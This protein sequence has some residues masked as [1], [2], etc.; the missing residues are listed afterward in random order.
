MTD[1]ITPLVDALHDLLDAERRALLAGDLDAIARMLA[2]KEDILARLGTVPGGAPPLGPLMDKLQRNQ[3]LLHGALDGIRTVAARI[4]DARQ[5]R[6]SLE[7]YDKRGQRRSIPAPAAS[8]ER[9]A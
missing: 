7:T 6:A 3:V 2:R 4:A 1:D 5:V 9:R 8:L